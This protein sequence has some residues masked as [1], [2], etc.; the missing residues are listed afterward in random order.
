M[1]AARANAGGHPRRALGA[2]GLLA[3]ILVLAGCGSSQNTAGGGVTAQ[4]APGG[5][6]GIAIPA[7]PAVLD[8]LFATTRSDQLVSRQLFEP[9][10]E[11]LTGPYGDVR[12]LPGLAV[13]SRPSPDQTIWHLRLRHGVR[14]QDGTLLNATA[15]L[16]NA[17][18][19][20]A[21]P[22]GA[23][24]LPGL[25][26]VDAPR[27]DLV[28]FILDHPDAAFPQRLASPRLGLVSPRALKRAGGPDEPLSRLARAGTGA[29]ELRQRRP[30]RV[31]LA[32]NTQWWGTERQLGPALDQVQFVTVP[33]GGGRAAL[34]KSGGVQIADRLDPAELAAID[35]DPLLTGIPG[36]GGL[37]LGLER[38]VRGIDSATQ[39]PALS[40]VWLTRIGVG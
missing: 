7:R 19:W 27:P 22:V 4:P 24:L 12:R 8:P 29:F 17:V 10:T 40:G 34:L 9:L 6:L 2:A 14:F 13:A 32:R 5:T 37:G 25:S 35:R 36:P 15:V 11:S 3:A 33:G 16:A 26:A 1:A 20:R 39:I 21:S 23:A 31:V 28:R 38:S 18:R 30:R